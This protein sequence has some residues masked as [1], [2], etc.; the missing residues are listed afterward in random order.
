MDDTHDRADLY[1]LLTRTTYTLP[2]T[3]IA[4]EN[5]H[6]Q[7]ESSIR[8]QPFL[9]AMLVSGRVSDGYTSSGSNELCFLT[10][11]RPLGGSKL[12]CGVGFPACS[13]S[14]HNPNPINKYGG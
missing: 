6:P 5:R 4:P 1:F 12:S 10:L 7:W 8:N 2:E 14:L 13:G 3:N 11:S 9:G